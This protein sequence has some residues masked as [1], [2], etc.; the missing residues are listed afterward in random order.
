MK[1]HNS[2]KLFYNREIHS[3]ILSSIWR[4]HRDYF[5][6]AEDSDQYYSIYMREI[7]IH[8]PW[9]RFSSISMPGDSIFKKNF[10]DTLVLFANDGIHYYHFDRDN[11]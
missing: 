9:N 7:T 4:G 2:V 8:K 1:V 3:H 6:L 10:S 5:N 11:Q